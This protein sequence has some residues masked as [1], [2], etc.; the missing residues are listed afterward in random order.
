MTAAKVWTVYV[1]SARGR[2]RYC[3]VTSAALYDR[4]SDHK[5]SARQG[6][7]TVFL[8]WL[9]E[10]LAAGVK[11][12]I[13]PISIHRTKAAGLAAE[14]RTIRQLRVEGLRLLNQSPGFQR[15][16]DATRKRLSAVKRGKAPSPGV[17]VI[18]TTT[19]ETF[20]TVK[21][22]ADRFDV[23]QSSIFQSL[24]RGTGRLHGFV[25]QRLP[26]NDNGHYTVREAV[27]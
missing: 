16:G 20:P 8:S 17:P 27:A 9:R 3:G 1:V 24:K 21:D 19:G 14:A 18:E 26:A 23:D 22:A 11:V 4:L 10:T 7:R 13:E 5:V 6:V 25:F 15:M 12:T 2:R